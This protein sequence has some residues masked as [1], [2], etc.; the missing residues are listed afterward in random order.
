LRFIDEVSIHA[1]AGHGGDGC[2]SFHREKWVTKGGPDG[3]NGGRGGDVIFRADRQ[4]GTLLELYFR[5]VQRAEDGR[6]GQG[7]RKSGK[8][9]ADLVVR[10]PCGTEI[11]DEE[12]GEVL[13]DLV[14]HG[15]EHRMKGGRGGA[16]N[17][18]FATSV[19]QTPDFAKPGRPGDERRLKLSLRILADVGIVGLPNAG[20]STLLAAV[21]A[22]RPRVAAYPFSTLAPNL[23]VVQLSD[24]DAMVLADM[25][26]LVEGA[27]EG[28]G[29]GDR[30]LRHLGRVRMLVHLVEGGER[31]GRDPVADYEVIRAELKAHS[32][33]LAGLPEV[34]VLSKADLP[35]TLDVERVLRPYL[36]RKRRKLWVVSAATGAGVPA[37]LAE[38]AARVRKARGTRTPAEAQAGG[39]GY[40]PL[41]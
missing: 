38:L 17:C 11:R 12:T 40:S 22:A 24:N 8:D 6:P 35:E 2:V 20:K 31:A 4:M 34:V 39:P 14:D 1:R 30:F 7:R 15:D 37:L 13:C 29:L 16:G 25:P 3:G 26:G 27:S 10:V 33:A 19:R 41:S 32:R 18:N 28:A 21:S 9:G 36:R 5:P 23:G